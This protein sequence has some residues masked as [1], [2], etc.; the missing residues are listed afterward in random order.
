VRQW[1]SRLQ[2]KSLAE[3]LQA[4]RGIYIDADPYTEVSQV[5]GELALVER[6]CP[7]LNIALRRPALCSVTVSTL[8]RL[9]GR[10]VTRQQRFQDGDGRCVF[11]VHTDQPIKPT[12]RFE[13]EEE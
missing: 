1:E 13:F 6:N 2:G 11:R 10:R 12:L 4:L 3:R 7:F 5:D 8:S 9:L